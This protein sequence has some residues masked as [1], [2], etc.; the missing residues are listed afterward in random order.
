MKHSL[1]CLFLLVPVF[2]SS[3]LG[4]DAE[5]RVGA[6]GAVDLSMDYTVSAA[7]DELGKLGA[8][9]AY[10]PIPVGRNDLELAARRAGGELRS[11]SRKDGPESFIIKATM[12]FPSMAAFAAFLDPTGS[13]A[14]F[15]ESGGK[16]TL[17]VRLSEGISPADKELIEFIRLAFADYVVAFRVVAPKNPSATGGMVVSG[18]TASFTMKSAELY[19]SQKPVILSVS[20]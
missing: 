3:C 10:I 6:D 20:W 5:A 9:A 1:H 15:N 7:L 19:A 18:R 16:A 17:S 12:H 14:S 11:W 4:L 8:N 13:S 2:L